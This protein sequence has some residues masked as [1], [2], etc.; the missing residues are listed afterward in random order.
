LEK[1]KA[2]DQKIIQGLEKKEIQ[3][4]KVAKDRN[5]RIEKKAEDNL[6]LLQN[7]ILPIVCS[8]MALFAVAQFIPL[9][10]IVYIPV[11]IILLIITFIIACSIPIIKQD[12]FG[13]RN[14]IKWRLIRK[15]DLKDYIQ[16]G[17]SHRTLTESN[18]N[19]L[20]G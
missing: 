7:I 5:E 13:I 14:K 2:E 9:L 11:R 12:Y 4:L 18:N 20:S 16:N 8:T 17:E 19:N 3:R 6:N 15:Y 1:S 10:S